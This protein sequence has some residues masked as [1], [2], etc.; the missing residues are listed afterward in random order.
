[1]PYTYKVDED[2][3]DLTCPENLH[4]LLVDDERLSRLVVTNMLQKSGYTVTCLESGQD[5]IELLNK[6]NFPYHLLML[7][8]AMPEVSGIQ[9][10][11]SCHYSVWFCPD[12]NKPE[13]HPTKFL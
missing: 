7:D 9:V 3:A 13:H 6:P 11:D 2:M 4:V 12:L 8:V 10:S 5:V 1:M